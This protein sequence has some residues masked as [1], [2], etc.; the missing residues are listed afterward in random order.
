MKQRKGKNGKVKHPNCPLHP[1]FDRGNQGSCS[2]QATLHSL[3]WT[4]LRG[5]LR[6]WM[7]V[8]I[9][10]KWFELSNEDSGSEEMSQIVGQCTGRIL[11][12]RSWET[13]G[14][15]STSEQHW[16]VVPPDAACTA[17]S[18]K[19]FCMSCDASE[20]H[21]QATQ[22]CKQARLQWEKPW[23]TA[24]TTMKQCPVQIAAW[25]WCRTQPPYVNGTPAQFPNEASMSL[26][27][28]ASTHLSA[29]CPSCF[30]AVFHFYLVVQKPLSIS[31]CH[32]SVSIRVFFWLQHL[33]LTVSIYWSVHLNSNSKCIL[34]SICAS[35][36]LA[37]CPSL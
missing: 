16:P 17:V 37:L 27:I 2:F 30:S 15:H 14:K 31:I 19:L 1:C 28:C 6:L 36:Y 12:R 32:L 20:R 5:V 4:S 35:T 7:G 21:Y 9:C 33:Y 11:G 18:V 8:D 13:T 29:R 10:D 34:P 23:P 22:Q 25:K 24:V 3:P 26:A